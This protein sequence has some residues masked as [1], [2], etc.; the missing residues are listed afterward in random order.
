[1]ECYL[2][3]P[4]RKMRTD[5]PCNDKNNKDTDNEPI[6]TDIGDDNKMYSRLV[7]IVISKLIKN[8]IKP[9]LNYISN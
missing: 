1:M 5:Q 9:F 6:A 3:Q 7:K 2:L 8:I 4:I